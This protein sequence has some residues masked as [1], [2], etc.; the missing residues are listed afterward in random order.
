MEFPYSLTPQS[1]QA[2]GAQE[3][4]IKL[5]FEPKEHGD[6]IP[7]EDGVMAHAFY[8]KVVII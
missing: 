8:P 5:S 1:L 4:D 3:P 2:K 7:F 6:G